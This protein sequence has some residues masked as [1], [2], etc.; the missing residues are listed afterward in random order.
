MGS[1]GRGA[2]S[3]AVFQSEVFT[4]TERE[5]IT[6]KAQEPITL[7]AVGR[8]LQVGP[9]RQAGRIKKR[10][11]VRKRPTLNIVVIDICLRPTAW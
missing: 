5:S 4:S 8:L 9:S 7:L 6:E 3:D 11:R 1:V 2:L 10:S